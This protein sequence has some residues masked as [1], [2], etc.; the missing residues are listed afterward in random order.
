MFPFVLLLVVVPSTPVVHGPRSTTDTTPTYRFSARENGVPAKRIHFLCAFDRPK[1]HACRARYSQR[2]SI[3]RHV[4]RVQAVD[5]AGFRSRIRKVRVAILRAGG[6]RLRRIQ[7][8]GRAFSLVD[9]AGSIW[10]ANFSSGTVQRIDP[11]TNQVVAQVEV[12]GEPYGLTAGAGS[13]WVGN[14]ALDSVARVDTATNSVTATITVGDRPLGLAYDS[15]NAAVWVADFGDSAVTRIDATT[16][17]VL[18]R[19]LIPGEHEDVELGF[20]SL[21]IPSEEGTLT[22][23]EFGRPRTRAAGSRAS[24]LARTQLP[25]R[26]RVR[27]GSRASPSTGP[28]SGSRTTTRT[29]FRG[30][31]P[32][33]GTCS[34]TGRP[35][36]GRATSWLPPAASGSRTRE[37]RP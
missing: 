27:L 20:G 9:A 13:V 7:V 2:L 11:R 3:G 1:L 32:R 37:P 16:N 36:S 4:L 6:P 23:V 18:A 12:G 31:T 10:V 19:A 22:R 21:W 28:T 17:A 34:G 35:A 30:S 26:S 14:N 25:R 8:G 24:T 33:T 29:R 5:P 15:A